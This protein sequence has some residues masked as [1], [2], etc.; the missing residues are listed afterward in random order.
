MKM[1]H[2]DLDTKMRRYEL[3]Y[4]QEVMPNC[5]VV[6]RAD[7][8][9][10]TN[11]MKKL[12]FKRPFDMRM[13]EIMAHVTQK[14]V[15][16]FKGIYGYT[17]SDEI[18]ILLPKEYED[19]NRKVRKLIT[20]ASSIASSN[21]TSKLILDYNIPEVAI[22]DARV[23]AFPT[24]EDVIDYFRW[25]QDDAN[26]CCLNTFCHWTAIQEDGMTARQATSLFKNQTV[27]FKNEFLMQHGI[28]YNEI[29]KWMRRGVG[30]V[31]EE[32]DKIGFNPILCE[33]T[34]VK[35]RR[36]CE[37]RNLPMKETYEGLMNCI[38]QQNGTLN[39]NLMKVN[40]SQL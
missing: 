4:N 38:L 16:N 10:F 26:R 7:G 28:N 21:F 14:L 40:F 1:K 5:W 2:K 18:S 12:E 25:R 6:I 9:G 32:Y 23:M 8:K 37:C 22:F 35:R 3:Q 34:T 13:S 19:Y 27:G 20:H 11:F 29:D 39:D 33:E 31:W 17:E 30:V 15:D 36:L 24:D